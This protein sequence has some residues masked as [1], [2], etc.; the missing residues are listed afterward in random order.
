[1]IVILCHPFDEAALWLCHQ[2]RLLG[3]DVEPVAV[4][5]LVYSRKI[6]HRLGDLGDTGEIHLSD[7][8][9]LRPESIRGLINRVCFLPLAH[10]ERATPGDRTY[11][12]EEL[13]AF[14]LAWLDS[15]A[16][17]VIN[18]AQPL[19]LDGG[20]FPSPTL[21]HLAAVAGLPTEGWRSDAR[22]G[23]PALAVPRA[24]QDVVVFDSRTF[25]PLIPRGL[26][27]GCRQLALLLGVPLLQ[28]TFRHSDDR[29]W[30]FHAA[31]GL[32]DFRVGGR[33]LAAA[34]ATTFRRRAAA[35]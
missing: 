33:P 8:R 30:L 3:L 24:T 14:L 20:A 23:D 35:A 19:S 13:N 22:P 31:H 15:V 18:P 21:F 16:G 25:G 11:A 28:I 10:I 5:A 6:V 34:I 32:A 1:M 12:S 29:G 26:Q 17:P 4:E 7:G 2:F 27:A 9:V